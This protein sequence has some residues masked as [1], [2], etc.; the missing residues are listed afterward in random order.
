MW[1]P[2][3]ITRVSLQILQQLDQCKSYPDFNN[4]LAFIFAQ[5]DS[6]PIEVRPV[7]ENVSCCLLHVFRQEKKDEIGVHTPA[8]LLYPELPACLEPC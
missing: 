7:S 6:L 4:Y 5:G 1:I 8:S 2:R 3:L